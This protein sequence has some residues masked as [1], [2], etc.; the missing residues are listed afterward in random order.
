MRLFSM[1]SA[2]A[3]LVGGAFQADSV[4]LLRSLSGPSGKTVGSDFVLDE[5][6][7]RFVFPKDNSLVVY[8]Q[9]EAPPGDH[10]LTGIW[11]QPDG[12]VVSI[13][14]DVTHV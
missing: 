8:F 11:K 3:L 9:W 10:S 1:V 12:R 2:L 4:K 13:S 14:P 7:N 5:T 6:R